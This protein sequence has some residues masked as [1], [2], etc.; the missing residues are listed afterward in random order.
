LIKCSLSPQVFSFS[1]ILSTKLFC[2]FNY[3]FLIPISFD[4][5]EISENGSPLVFIGGEANATPIEEWKGMT[6]SDCW[7]SNG[8]T[9][10]LGEIFNFFVSHKA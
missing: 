3:Y 8:I 4:V 10:V 1:L 2:F 6:P 7:I 9:D 5:K